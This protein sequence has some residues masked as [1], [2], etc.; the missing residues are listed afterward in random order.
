[1]EEI[2]AAKKFAVI[3]FCGNLFLRI[4]K[5]PAKIAK[6]R[7]C[8]NLVPHGTCTKLTYRIAQVFRKFQQ[9]QQPFQQVSAEVQL[10]IQAMRGHTIV[11]VDHVT[12]SFKVDTFNSVDSLWL[13]WV[14]SYTDRNVTD[15][16]YPTDLVSRFTDYVLFCRT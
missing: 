7:T 11:I 2:F 16:F 15:S 1:M 9:N 13:C 5:K 3:L 12:G 10:G 8:K 4:A 6:I 14:Y